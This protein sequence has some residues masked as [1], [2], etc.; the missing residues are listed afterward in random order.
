MIK[1]LLVDD[2]ELV[3]TGIS[4][5][6]QDVN[7]IEVIDEANSG[8]SAIDSVKQNTPDVV[9]MDVNMPGIGGLEATSKLLKI[10]PD[11]KVIIV[12]VHIVSHVFY[13]R[14]IYDLKINVFVVFYRG[15]ARNTV[16]EQRLKA[17]P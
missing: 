10:H 17:R 1:V 13:V 9:L 6:L 14:L 11:L 12:T 4:R 8:E 15:K 2:H 3:R 5:L 16:F 7:G